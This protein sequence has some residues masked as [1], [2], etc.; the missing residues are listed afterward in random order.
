MFQID[1]IPGCSTAPLLDEIVVGRIETT[2][3]IMTTLFIAKTVTIPPVEVF[4]ETRLFAQITTGFA[5]ACYVGQFQISMTYFQTGAEYQLEKQ[6]KKPEMPIHD[7]R[8]DFV[9]NTI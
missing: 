4:A 1:A 7:G 3:T 9:L 6:D 2:V 5:V 8:K